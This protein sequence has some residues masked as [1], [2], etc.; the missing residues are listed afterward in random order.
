[1]K[2][3]LYNLGI[4]LNWELTKNVK[5]R[6]KPRIDLNDKNQDSNCKIQ[7]QTENFQTKT[8]V[9]GLKLEVDPNRDF[10][11][12]MLLEIINQFDFLS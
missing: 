1:M 2:S 11:Q 7:T 4:Q 10:N 3:T 9:F 12:I 6:I 8:F 5:F